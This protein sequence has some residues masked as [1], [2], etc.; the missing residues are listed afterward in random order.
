MEQS[1]K[2]HR[3][4]IEN[5]KKKTSDIGQTISTTTT[6]LNVNGLNNTIKG[7]RL[8]G[9]IKTMKSKCRL[10]TV[11]ILKIQKQNRLTKKRVNDTR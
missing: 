3:Q 9:Q 11:D 7:H 8:S 4:S 1:N 6:T 2:E 5:K 10:S